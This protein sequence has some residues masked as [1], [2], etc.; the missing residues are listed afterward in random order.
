MPFFSNQGDWAD[1]FKEFKWIFSLKCTL[2]NLNVTTKDWLVYF[3]TNF[4]N[5]VLGRYGEFLDT[6][7]NKTILSWGYRRS[8]VW[9]RVL[10]FYKKLFESLNLHQ[11][12]EPT[13]FLKFLLFDFTYPLTLANHLFRLIWIESFEFGKHI[14]LALFVQLIFHLVFTLTIT[15]SPKPISKWFGLHL[16]LSLGF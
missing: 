2:R 7:C 5:G 15:S 11:V 1:L 8:S 14:N 3:C 6:N 9:Q 13:N 16:K 10:K 4:I 12:C